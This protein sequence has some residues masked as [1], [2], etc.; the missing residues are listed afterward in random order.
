MKLRL[1]IVLIL[2]NLLKVYSQENILDSYNGDF[3]NGMDHWR[4]FE[5]PGNNGSYAVTAMDAISGNYAMEINYTTDYG[6]VVDRGFDNWNTGVPVTEDVIYTLKAY[7]KGDTNAS[8]R[9]VKV[10]FTIGFM[11]EAGNVISQR[12]RDHPLTEVYAE[13][14]L[15]AKAPANAVSCWV[16]FR[17]F[18][19]TDPCA[20]LR[21][22]YIDNVRILRPYAVSVDS[23]GA[24]ESE[25]IHLSNYPNPFIDRT[26]I[27]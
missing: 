27:S 22:M 15:P 4:F 21:R 7:V 2:F 12:D 13:K 8:E 9:L 10:K 16:A 20:P 23:P 18:D 14:S 6:D 25:T 5:V 26:T 19:A 3:E 1:L 17:L 24:N 11:D